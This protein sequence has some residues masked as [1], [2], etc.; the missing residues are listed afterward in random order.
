MPKIACLFLYNTMNFLRNKHI[1]N[2]LVI[3]LCTGCAIKHSTYTLEDIEKHRTLY[4][5]KGKRKSLTTLVDIYLDKNQPHESRLQALR[6]ISD[7]NDPIVI[8][9]LQSSIGTASLIDLEIMIESVETLVSFHQ[10]SSVDSLV[11]GLANTEK[12]VMEIRE[13]IINAIGE[14][15]TND[16]IYTLLELYEVSRSNHARMNK[17]LTLTLGGM[18]DDRVIPFLMQIA[19]DEETEIH[20]R[21]RAVDIL[22]RKESPELVDFFIEML[23]DPVTRDKVNE[24]AMNVLG[25]FNDERMVFALLE[26]YQTGKHQY[27]AM[28]N[29]LMKSL[30]EYK[31]PAIKPV[32]IEI[33]KTDGFPRSLRIKAIRGL[34]E[35]D[36][37]A[38]ADEVVEILS[39]PSNYIYYNEIVTLLKELGV[40]ENYKPELRE[41]AFNAMKLDIK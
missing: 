7:I 10:N 20:I 37:P 11:M 9:A 2:Y 38:S 15:G 39:Y 41:N 5:Q 21:N 31:N 17:L 16:E 28:L 18:D 26:A 33:A 23:G 8:D 4:T 14:N 3:L 13:S 24:Y 29:T 19:N 32:F 36:D 6:V 27:Y 34:A 25:E 22:A 1:I 12:K 30:G 40:Y 35:F